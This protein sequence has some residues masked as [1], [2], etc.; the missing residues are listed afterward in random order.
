MPIQ[1]IAFDLDGTALVAHKALPKRNRLALC[2]AGKRG[3]LLV[4]AT[5]RVLDF[6]PSEI[7]GIPYVQYAITANGGGVYDL[8]AKQRIHA[9][10]LSTEKAMAVQKIL[11][12]YSL[13]IE[14]YLNGAAVTTEQ[15]PEK[16]KKR[17]NLPESKYHF[18]SKAY[19]YADD[20]NSLLQKERVT[21]EKINLPYLPA[22]IRTEVRNRLSQIPG[23]ALC[24]S[25]PDNLE[26]NDSAATK[27]HALRALANL[28]GLPLENCM[29]I[30]DNGNDVE[31]LKAAGVSVAMGNSSPEA[32]AAAQFTTE[33][34]EQD[35]LALAIERFAL[36]L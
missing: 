1:L 34:C 22:E 19:T 26:V 7:T 13:F 31:L 25:I 10:C 14:Y 27:G 12:E 28:L 9:A 35:G 2:E 17:Y 24:S 21:P 11:N 36:Q 8:R 20:F 4:P 18:L 30:G 6:L 29:A 3:I 15:N 32:F 23:I 33:T 16:A 5:G